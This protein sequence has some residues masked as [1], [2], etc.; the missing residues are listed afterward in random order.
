MAKNQSRTQNTIKNISSAFISQMIAQ[1]VGLI[2][3][4]F[5]IHY[6][7]SVY[8]GINGL[9]TNILQ[10]LSLAE[11][12]VGS[13]LVYSMYRP[14]AENDVR[15]IKAYMNFYKRVYQTIGIVVLVGG[16]ALTPFL[17]FFMESRPDIELL[18]MIYALYVFRSA[19]SYF[20][21]YKQSVFRADQKVYIITMTTMVT[22]VVRSVVEIL[23]LVCTKQFIVYLLVAVLFNYVNN[24]VLAV[25]AD[26]MYP[27]LKEKNHE[28]LEK[29]K[30]QKLVKNVKA[31]FVHKMSAVLLNSIDSIVL[32]KYISV[33]AVGLYSNYSVIVKMIKHVIDVIG[34]GI[35]PSMGNLFASGEG[36]HAYDVFKDI[37][38]MYVWMVGFCSTAFYLLLNPFVEIWAGKEYLLSEHTVVAIIISFYLQAMLRPVSMVRTAN[39]LFYNDRYFALAQCGINLIASIILSKRFGITGVFIATSVAVLL[40]LFWVQAYLVYKN[41]FKKSVHIYFAEYGKYVAMWVLI[42]LCCKFVNSWISLPN[43]YIAFILKMMVAVIVPNGIFF[44]ATRHKKEF[45][46]FSDK[47]RHIIGKRNRGKVLER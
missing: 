34:D 16:L 8:L 42:A 9:F 46:H 31:M 26:R 37:F 14:M 22:T 17:D 19:S 39:G 30:V 10:V 33:I 40:T 21:A 35:V 13:A 28:K 44:L 15:Q 12:G 25:I 45:Q 20:F 32:S 43:S 23:I 47:I 27:F 11:L 3:R 24:I 7:S 6:L 2:V 41:V 1:V 36:E 4:T 29:E 38:Y 5:F 18:E